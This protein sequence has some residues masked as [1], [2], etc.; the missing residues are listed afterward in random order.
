MQHTEPSMP[1][2]PL[3]KASRRVQNRTNTQSWSDPSEI[4]AEPKEDPVQEQTNDATPA[5]PVEKQP[6][7]WE[8][9]NDKARRYDREMLKEW[10]ENLSILLVFVSSCAPLPLGETDIP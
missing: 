5:A 6:S 8:Q 10:E 7:P 4:T 3:L 9:Y 2:K 1:A